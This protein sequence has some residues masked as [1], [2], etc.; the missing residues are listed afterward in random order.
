V[1]DT[2]SKVP[3]ARR[4]ISFVF[5]IY[6]EQAT[7]P[8]LYE[9]MRAVTDPLG[10]RYD[11]DFVFVD[12][13]SKDD[14]LS[15]LLGLRANDPRVAVYS[16]ARNYGHQTAITAGVDVTDADAVIVMDSDLQD[17]PEVSVELIRAWEEGAD[18]VY[19]Q[20]R[21]RQDSAFKRLTAHAFYWTLSR[22]AAIDIPRNTGDFRLMDRKVVDQLR[23]YREHDRFV[24]GLV[25]YIGFTQVAVPFDRD[26]R[27]AGQT[28]YPL[29]KMLRLAGDGI[30]G[31]STLPLRFIS[32]AGSVLALLSFLWVVY[33]VITRLVSPDT[34]V[35]GWTFVVAGMFLLG[36]IQ[37]MMLGILG[38]YIGRIY[39]E[40]Q[41][42]PLYA[43]RGEWAGDEP[44]P[45]QPGQRSASREEPRART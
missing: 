24:R 32:R 16:F 29:R 2:S 19:A 35:E 33:L 21:S 44:S 11:V 14:S 38:S 15:L 8:T 12:D 18:V 6:N 17:P 40:T 41:N 39:I 5:P 28:G 1:T 23:R 26:A 34:L 13:G 36:G 3:G 7:I 9:R 30:F 4:R 20:R 43:F 27:F 31:F 25:A 22:L 37:M 10:E 45:A 42:R